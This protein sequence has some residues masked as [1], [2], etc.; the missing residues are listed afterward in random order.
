MQNKCLRCGSDAHMVK[1]CTRPTKRKDA[2]SLQAEDA[3]DEQVKDDDQHIEEDEN[4]EEDEPEH[5]VDVPDDE[6]AELDPDDGDYELVD[7]EEYVV[8]PV[9]ANALD[10]GGK[11]KGKDKG[12]RGTGKGGDRKKKSNIRG[13][14]RRKGQRRQTPPS[15]PRAFTMMV[16]PPGL[17]VSMRMF[18]VERSHGGQSSSGAASSTPLGR[19]PDVRDPVMRRVVKEHNR[20]RRDCFGPSYDPYNPSRDS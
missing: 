19:K 15:K 3:Q 13:Q 6:D 8:E 11:G 9:D 17:N 16:T 5:K 1:S 18:S 4:G 20:I 14:T 7:A 2:R 10:K 12:Q